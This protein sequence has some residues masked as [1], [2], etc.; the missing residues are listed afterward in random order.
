MSSELSM[1]ESEMINVEKEDIIFVKYN[2]SEKNLIGLIRASGFQRLK[3][4][5]KKSGIIS[6][7][8]NEKE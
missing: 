2:M 5:R 4:R 8:A 7:F 3:K 1:K 6:M